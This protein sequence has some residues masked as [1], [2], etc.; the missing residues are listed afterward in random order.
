MIRAASE[1]AAQAATA[2][3]ALAVGD[4]TGAEE[5]LAAGGV[6]DTGTATR[7][8]EGEASG[9]AEAA[10]GGGLVTT[11]RTA[12]AVGLP[13]PLDVQAAKPSESRAMTAQARRFLMGDAA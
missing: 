5:G 9:E 13:A 2:V 12:G 1:L 3:E 11:L 4:G 8:A 7:A 6:G 10:G